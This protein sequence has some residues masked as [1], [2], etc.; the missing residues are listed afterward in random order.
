MAR[1]YRA[2]AKRTGKTV[3][4]KALHK[5]RQHDDRAV[6]RFVQ[7]AQI[8]STL[9][10]SRIV[11]VE[12]LGQFAG[13][14]YFLVMDF[15][16]GT[17]LQARLPSGRLPVMKAVSILRDVASAVQHAHDHGGIH[18]DLK[19]ANVLI[20]SGMRAAGDSDCLVARHL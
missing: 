16:D 15:V 9:R 20:G 7:E 3:A 6:A 17:D 4:V 10:H 5:A 2:T 14:G 12:G 11:G 1:N 13:G 19:P 8:L 18:C